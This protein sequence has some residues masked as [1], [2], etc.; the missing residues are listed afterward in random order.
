MARKLVC[1]RC[2]GEELD[3]TEARV[4]WTDLQL[5]KLGGPVIAK[6]E[7]CPTCTAV[8]RRFLDGG[9]IGEGTVMENFLIQ[10][11]EQALR[12]AVDKTETFVGGAP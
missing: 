12:E 1:D 8:V 2:L 7:V 9:K 10:S 4:E 3:T 6:A 11:E 5:A